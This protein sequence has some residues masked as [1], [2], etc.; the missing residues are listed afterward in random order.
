MICQ[1][2]PRIKCSLPSMKSSEW[3]LTT[4]QP[5][6]LAELITMLAFSEIVKLFKGLLALGKFKTLVSMV[7]G[8]ES[9]INLERIKPSLHSSKIW[10]VS[11]GI[12]NLL[13][14]SASPART[15]L[16]CLVNSCFS[17]S[18]MVC[19]V[20]EILPPRT[21]E[22]LAPVPLCCKVPPGALDEE[23][24]DG[25]CCLPSRNLAINST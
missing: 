16:M 21:I 3:T 4:T 18:L 6:A 22:A 20:P 1:I 13:P 5:M 14:T 9:L 8:T 17:S 19:W 11:T 2:K 25:A 7:S 15:L 24:L 12:G 23:E 10:K